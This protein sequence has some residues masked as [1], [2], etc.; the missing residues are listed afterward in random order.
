M[1]PG[2][3]VINWLISS[4]TCPTTNPTVQAVLNFLP[5]ALL[6]SAFPNSRGVLLMESDVNCDEKEADSQANV[7]A[8][9]YVVIRASWL[10]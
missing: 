7:M 6:P 1:L 8:L 2:S 3:Q 5:P 10:L 9:P 4:L